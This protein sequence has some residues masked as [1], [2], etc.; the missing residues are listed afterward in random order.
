M[1]KKD[2]VG[3]NTCDQYLSMSAY[4]V[5]QVVK[6]GSRLSEAKDDAFLR[7]VVETGCIVRSRARWRRE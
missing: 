7:H 2:E 5:G 1:Y 6:I 3:N 4:R